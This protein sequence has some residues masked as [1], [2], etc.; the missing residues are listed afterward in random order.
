MEFVRDVAV[1]IFARQYFKA[2]LG[3]VLGLVF[4][5]GCEQGPTPTVLPVEEE[6]TAT[7]VV[8]A[9][10]P[11]ET[12]VLPTLYPTPSAV[13]SAS[14]TAPLPT[15]TPRA[16][17]T[18]IDFTELVVE[19]RFSIPGLAL[20][21]TIRGNVSSQLELTDETTGE[22]VTVTDVPGVMFE[23]QQS[24]PETELSE[25]PDGCELCVQ[26][27]YEL[28]LTGETGE[29]WLEDPVLLASFENFFSAHLGP[30]FPPDTVVGLRRSATPYNVAHT[31]ALTADGAMWRWTATEAELSGP[32]DGDSTSLTLLGE[33]NLENI[34]PEYLGPC[35]EGSGFERL[36]LA[37]ESGESQVDIVCPEL[38]LP[39]SLLPLYLQLD[40]LADE[41]TAED[42]LPQPPPTVP[43]ESVVYYQRRDGNRLILFAN[44]QAQAISGDGATATAALAENQAVD[45]ALTLAES[46]NLRLGVATLEFG[47]TSNILIARGSDGVYEATWSNLPPE[48]LMQVVEELDALLEELLEDAES[49]EGG[50][51]TPTS[52]P[53][54][55]ETPEAT[56]DE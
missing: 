34:G 9:A 21:R 14:A 2:L 27:S 42:A 15:G 39:L 31:V 52:T 51:P 55:E 22:V 28:F 37:N 41:K 43:L 6:P 16:T 13:P 36:F 46:G 11:E 33:L 20:E 18:P 38:S 23:L 10:V 25:V 48:N 53:S 24:L 19:A 3:L 4:V 54:E 47:N 44:G 5:V 49:P 50:T 12:L 8:E 32:E 17:A 35:P 29:G 1:K 26:L 30:H 40:G 7:A 45:T 56:P